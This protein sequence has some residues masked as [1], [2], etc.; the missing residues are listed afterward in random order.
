MATIYQIGPHSVALLLRTLI[1]IATPDKKE[2]ALQA[3]EGL[4]EAVLERLP[5]GAAVLA[6]KQSFT[7]FL[8][9]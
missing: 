1:D 8:N 7:K 3:A 9:S 2:F 6:Q 4:K 5:S